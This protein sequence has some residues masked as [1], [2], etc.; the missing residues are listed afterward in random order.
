MHRRCLLPVTDCT[1]G[2]LSQSA[3][4][5]PIKHFH[6]EM[7]TAAPHTN[8]MRLKKRLVSEGVFMH[9]MPKGY[10]KGCGGY[11][12]K[13][14]NL[15]FH[16]HHEEW[17]VRRNIQ[18]SC[19]YSCLANGIKMLQQAAGTWT[20]QNEHVVFGY[21]KLDQ[22][23]VPRCGFLKNSIILSDRHTPHQPPKHQA[24]SGSRWGKMI[25]SMPKCFLDL[26]SNRHEINFPIK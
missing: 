23:S 21:L 11:H 17:S 20:L 9:S 6:L 26:F 19:L 7:W 22:T 12:L 25:D 5:S 8:E 13:Q 18:Y 10:L 1:L 3:G 24:L 15:T 14:H 4:W 2:G 16:Y